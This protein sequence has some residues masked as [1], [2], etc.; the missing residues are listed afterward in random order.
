MKFRF[1][2]L[3]CQT[4]GMLNKKLGTMQHKPPEQRDVSPIQFGIARVLT[5]KPNLELLRPIITNTKETRQK[6][7]QTQQ[8]DTKTIDEPAKQITYRN[9]Y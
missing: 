8:R 3:N 4:Q 6:I 7:T 2:E 5:S 1:L 9:G